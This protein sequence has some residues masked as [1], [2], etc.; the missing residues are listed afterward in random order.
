MNVQDYE[1]CFQEMID[2]PRHQNVASKMLCGHHAYN[3]NTKVC[4]RRR[5]GDSAPDDGGPLV[6]QEDTAGVIKGACR[7]NFVTIWSVRIVRGEG[8]VVCV[9]VCQTIN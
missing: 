4:S 1:S 6:C 2:S 7:L 3:G 5:I 9:W 8:S